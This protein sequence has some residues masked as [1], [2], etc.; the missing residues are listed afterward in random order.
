MNMNSK[1]KLR[2]FDI[3]CLAVASFFSLEI[4]ASQA[5][6]GPSMIFCM[7]TIGVLYLIC[8]GLIC[9]E[10]GATYPDQGGIY[11][12][13]QK[14]FGNRWAA[15]TTWWYWV[16]VV[17][18]IPSVLV[19]L[20]I[21]FQQLFWPDM[22]TLTMTVLAIIGIWVIVL[23]NCFSIRESKILTNVGSVLKVLVTVA[24]IGGSIYMLVT[25]GSQ[26]VFSAE[27]II[28]TFDIHFL[29][30]IP[31]Y[32]YGLTGLDLISCNAGE[33]ENPKK[34]VPR[35][36]IIACVV[37]VVCYIIASVCVLVVLPMESID[38]ASGMIDAI[39]AIYG[40]SRII[41][42]LIGASLVV[43]Y[44]S[45]IFSWA[46]G[47]NSVALEAGETGELPRWF[48]ITNKHHAP[49]GPAVMLGVAATALQLVYGFTAN[50]SSGLFWTL[51]AFTSIV[52]FLPYLVLSFALIKLRKIDPDADTSFRIPGKVFPTVL[53]IV[54]FILLAI[55]I[56]GYV[57]PPEGEDPVV[58][59][60]VIIAGIGLSQIVGEILIKMAE[61][62]KN[63]AQSE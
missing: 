50:S 29:A 40:T 45:Y 34:D 31:V 32:I 22:S 10:L 20:L 52:F 6:L 24:L 25:S 55:A 19:S 23:L 7:L 27:T 26:N 13:T 8:H 11:V 56:V 47:G 21:V 54:H 39:I 44:I 42:I 16:N 57:L 60:V 46:I 3:A 62:K 5:S 4:V 1:K 38:P 9:A 17:A 59:V 51:L 14:A 48:A 37:S 2:L 43:V 63:N 35:A 33:M 30:L 49:V 53:A 28:P 15:R 18:F 36:L 41:A 61:K 58:Y 12:W